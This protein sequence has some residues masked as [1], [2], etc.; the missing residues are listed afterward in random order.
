MQKS[1]GSFPPGSPEEAIC[2]LTAPPD[3]VL[4][5]CPTRRGSPR[6]GSRPRSRTQPPRC[7]SGA[8][9]AAPDVTEKALQPMPDTRLGDKRH[10]PPW[11]NLFPHACWGAAR[12]LLFAAL[13]SLASAPLPEAG[14]GYPPPALPSRL[15]PCA[16][17]ESR[18]A[19]RASPSPKHAR[20]GEVRAKDRL[21]RPHAAPAP[22]GAQPGSSAPGAP[23]TGGVCA[24]GYVNQL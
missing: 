1:P 18:S 5:P 13:A 24:Q 22:G 23:S 19:R 10:F 11:R 15:V 12:A 14:H 21:S 20:S 16:S 3:L 6:R 7:R 17:D 8:A 2:T 4:T 9:S